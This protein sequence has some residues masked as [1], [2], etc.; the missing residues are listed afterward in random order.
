MEQDRIVYG[1]DGNA[2][3]FIGPAA[4]SVYAMAVIASGLTL[5]AKTGLRM[6]RHQGPG[7]MMKAGRRYLDAETSGLIKA[8]DYHGMSAAL[9]VRVQAEKARIGY[10]AE[11]DPGFEAVAACRSTSTQVSPKGTQA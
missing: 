5:Y 9:R 10:A 4:V 3:A 2:S 8:R 11:P 7:V 1:S 6:S